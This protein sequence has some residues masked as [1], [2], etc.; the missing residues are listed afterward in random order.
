MW[1]TGEQRKQQ[2]EN[3]THLCTDEII[4]VSVAVAVLIVVAYRVVVVVVGLS[5]TIKLFVC[6]LEKR[7][8]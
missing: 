3:N 2:H 6:L 5:L 4:F 1:Q 8:N 7:W